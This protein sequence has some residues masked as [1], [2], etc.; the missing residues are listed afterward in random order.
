[1]ADHL[2]LP[3]RISLDSRRQGSAGGG[4]PSRN[5]RSHG[6]RL[7]QQLER[8]IAVAREIRV[9]EG[10]DPGLVFKVQA[11]GRLGDEDWDR[12]GLVLLGDTG[13][14]T[15]FVLSRADVP[16][17]LRVQLDRYAEGPDQEGG[18]AVGRSF[19]NALEEIQ[20]YGRDDRRGS[21]LP[22]PATLAAPLIVDVVVWPSADGDE[23]RRRLRNVDRVLERFNGEK[24]AR[25]ERAQYTVARVRIGGK[26]LDALLGLPVV[27]RV[28]L[29]P[30][31]FIEPSDWMTRS[32]GDLELDARDGEPIGVLD[33]GI[34][35]GHP[36][37]ADGVASR[38]AFPS[39][40]PWGAIGPH[41]T[42]VAGLSA[43]GDFESALRNNRPLVRRSPVHEARVLE[44][45]PDLPDRTR[46]AETTTPHQAV[47]AAIT[48]L[49]DQEG[50]RVFVLSI[51]DPDPFT[52]PHVS[53][54]TERLD[55]LIRER[56]IIV[57]CAAGNHSVVPLRAE[58]ASGHH[59]FSDYPAY[60]LEPAARVAEPAAAA[61]AVV[62]GSIARSDAPQTLQGT[63]RVGD[64]AVA[65]TDELSP[66][67]RTGPG[68][69]RTI[70]PDVVEY[71]GN[72]V[73]NDIGRLETENAGVGIVSL[74]F[75]PA[76]R[77]FRVSAGTSFAAP[78]VARLAAD[79]WA[80]YPDAS[81]NLIR[82]LIA[83]SCRVPEATEAQFPV[84]DSRLRALGYGHPAR[85]LALASGGPRAVMYFDGAMPTDTVSVHPVP[86]PARFA[87]GRALRRISVALAF[88]PPVRRQRREYL[89]GTISF[90]LLRNVDPEEVRERYE[91]QGEARVDLYSDRRRL[92][93]TPS[94]RRTTNST[95][96][97]RHFSPKLL[98]VDDGD[99]YYLVIKHQKAAWSQSGD[100]TYAIAVE[101][102]EE[103]RLDVDLYAEVQQ[104]VQPRARARVR[105]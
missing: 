95:L 52:G 89:A 12:K 77:L 87:R 50:V 55:A 35:D 67:S 8:A 7:G 76:G 5:P 72:W 105:T 33:D 98:N 61:L 39:D 97:L 81:A 34:A 78:R 85:D 37:L 22:E 69:F 51:T 28:R 29:P 2:L 83:S 66:F 16:D 56:N 57:V 19:F 71:G 36:L 31:P 41:G 53:L 10:V 60:L 38:R 84:E 91:R 100:Q 30:T 11:S 27:E 18:A 64:R 82:A 62:V 25:D 4:P 20:P 86:I 3:D 59:A 65:G 75:G 23:A 104:Q 49:N 73:L 40:Y 80:A 9:V 102:A 103:Q 68:A 13:D 96:Q 21:D 47:E 48:T 70:K 43:F 45:H 88:D 94:A 63:T 99:T 54:W 17:E 24:I 58:M 101:L 6:R 93:L 44:P 1:M 42:M 15:Y 46:F 92:D 90:D 79:L 74:G 32:A 26:G 14:W